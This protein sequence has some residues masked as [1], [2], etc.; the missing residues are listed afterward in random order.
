MKG[1]LLS[2]MLITFLMT[3]FSFAEQNSER[4][5]YKCHLRLS[6]QSEVIHQFVSP[7]KTQTEFE[8]GLPGSTV[9]A[10]DGVTGLAIETV[11]QCVKA[12]Q[13]F[14]GKQAQELEEKTPF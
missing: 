1:K 11:Y 14:K 10:A 5:H 6:D 4:I 2:A 7:G 13:K 8:E 12:K 3:S 9:Y